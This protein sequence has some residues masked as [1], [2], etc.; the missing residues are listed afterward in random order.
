LSSDQGLV[1]AGREL[2]KIEEEKVNG[3]IYQGEDDEQISIMNDDV[4][5][6]ERLA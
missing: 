1:E 4:T 3:F 2:E 5:L 6:Y